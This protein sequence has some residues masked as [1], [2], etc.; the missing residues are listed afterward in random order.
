MRLVLEDNVPINLLAF[1]RLLSLRQN[2][3][4]MDDTGNITE[5]GQQNVDEEVGIATS[6]EEDTQRWEDDGKDDLADIAGGERHDCGV[7]WVGV[8]GWWES[9]MI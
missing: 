3:Q 9:G 1:D 6:L 5:D 4:S 2:I 8:S 7:V